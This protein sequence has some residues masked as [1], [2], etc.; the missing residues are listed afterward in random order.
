MFVRFV[1]GKED[2][3]PE[4]EG[5][6]G[7][8]STDRGHLTKREVRKSGKLGL[9]SYTFLM[10]APSTKACSWRA[11]GVRWWEFGPLSCQLGWKNHDSGLQGGHSPVSCSHTKSST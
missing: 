10:G 6:E 8:C 1:E 7:C 4:Y 11:R 5:F 9:L 2:V 3:F